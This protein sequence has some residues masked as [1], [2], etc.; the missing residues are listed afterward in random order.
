MMMA[1]LQPFTLFLQAS[2][3]VVGYLQSLNTVFSSLPR[4]VCGYIADVKGRKNAI[5]I[6]LALALLSF[7]IYALATNWYMLIPATI[8]MGLGAAFTF[9]AFDALVAESVDEKFRA[10]AY[11]I[12]STSTFLAGLFA[13]IIGGRIAQIYSYSHV[14]W[15]AFLAT[16]IS[17]FLLTAFIRETAPKSR[18]KNGRGSFP[19]FKDI[20]SVEPGAGGLYAASAIDS[21]AWG[22]TASILPGLL[23]ATFS[24]SPSDIGLIYAVYAASMCLAQIPMGWLADKYERRKLLL[25]V[26]E[27]TGCIFL[28]GLLLST[29]LIHFIVLQV[30]MGLCASTWIS[31]LSALTAGAV[32][33]DKRAEALG[34]IGGLRMLVSVPSP[35]IA[36]S[37]YMV[38]GFKAPVIVNLLIAGLNVIVISLFIHEHPVSLTCNTLN[39]SSQPQ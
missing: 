23:T 20:L 11:S 36:G 21:F 9:P 3:A 26:S 27:V 17:L 24:F 25:I 37:I 31:P 8:L 4:P 7:I 28:A 29:Q 32:P 35:A 38:W 22:F 5:S 6:G 19:R 15:L 30:L 18:F 1:V 34:K 12:V 2:V 16:F 33:V 13:P 10:T 14:F 39:R